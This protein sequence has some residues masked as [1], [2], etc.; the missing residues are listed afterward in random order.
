MPPILYRRLPLN[1]IHPQGWMKAQLWHDLETGF[2]GQLDHLT[3]HAT[4]DLFA[5]R[6]E[7]S[8][9]QYAWWDAET[10]GNWL[11]GGTMMAYFSQ[12]SSRVRLTGLL[13]ALL[14]TQDEDGY[15]GIYSPQSRY[16]H[17]NGENGELWAQ[18]RALLP[19][20]SWYEFTGETRILNA[21]EKAVHLTM[22]HYGVG[23]SYFRESGNPLTL[24]I[25]VTHGLNYVDVVAW[26]YALTG[27]KAYRDFGVWLYD[28]F[29]ALSV[30]FAND[31]LSTRSLSDPNRHMSG[32]AVH[33]AE[34]LRVLAW[35]YAVT[36][37]EDL[38]QAY[39][40]AQ[41]KL[42][43][44][45]LPNGALLGDESLHGLPSSE[46]GYEYCTLTEQSFSL[47]NRLTYFGTGAEQIESLLFNAAQGA[48]FA[49]GSGVAYLST[50]SRLNALAS[51]HDS[52]S[53]LHGKPGRFKFSP[54]H[55]DVACCCNP[56]ATRILAHYISHQW[57]GLSD[58]SGF[59]ALLYGACHLTTEHQGIRVHIEQHTQYPFEDSVRFVINPAE[60]VRFRLILRQPAWAEAVTLTLNGIAVN[61]DSQ[62]DGM[63]SIEQEWQAGDTVVL[64]WEASPRSVAYPNGEVAVL[65]GA[66]QY[67]YPI[68]HRVHTIKT[69]A[70]SALSDVEL[71]PQD[72]KMAYHPVI[73]EDQAPHLG[74]HLE[75]DNQEQADWHTPA[76][77]LVGKTF[78]LVPMGCAPLRRSAFPLNNIS[79]DTKRPEH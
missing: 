20:L 23:R 16:Q 50:D 74:L 58:G 42:R 59:A 44:Y 79:S 76:L 33:T 69:Y 70:N 11:W 71:Y 6:I 35:A 10:R 1:S 26:L 48:R 78:T 60:A 53:F 9:E 40:Q 41:T 37:R 13:E 64:A 31:D 63:L 7:S 75:R 14:A 45:T 34:H 36:E 4:R 17:G 28:D 15:L 55:E 43:A 66:L 62:K 47:L 32:H 77:R 56:N 49:D 72:V 54:T 52:Y 12:H 24:L 21:V 67:V 22:Q 68:A 51:R 30:P 2:A 8:E 19:L 38:R 25:G 61:T 27:N 18:S 46:I 29:C 5:Q 3:T 65:R 39:I 73:L 57:M